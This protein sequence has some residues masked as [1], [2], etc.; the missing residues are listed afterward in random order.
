[1]P[2]GKVLLV[3]IAW[4][5]LFITLNGGTPGRDYAGFIIVADCR[6]PPKDNVSLIQ[7]NLKLIA[8]SPSFNNAKEIHTRRIGDKFITVTEEDGNK[9]EET[10]MTDLE[11]NEFSQQWEKDWT[12]GE[13]VD[14]LFATKFYRRTGKVIE[15]QVKIRKTTKSGHELKETLVHQY[16]HQIG[17]RYITVT[18]VDGVKIVDTQMTEQELK[19]FTEE[20]EKKWTSWT[21]ARYPGN[22]AGIVLGTF[23]IAAC[24]LEILFMP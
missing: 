21:K 8:V 13:D 3:A 20:W 1:M 15:N 11:V 5:L 12:E 22:L 7:E 4:F 2:G 9:L 16:T 19:E 6:K 23:I 18:E 14:C 24:L 17:H 10:K